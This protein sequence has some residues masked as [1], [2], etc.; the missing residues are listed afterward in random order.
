M[1]KP[2]DLVLDAVREHAAALARVGG[3][4]EHDVRRAVDGA[5]LAARVLDAMTAPQVE[6]MER[7]LPAAA[8]ATKP[9][10]RRTRAPRRK[11]SEATAQPQNAAAREPDV[12]VVRPIAQG[13]PDPQAWR[14]TA[15][16]A[17]SGRA[18]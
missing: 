9:R 11:R 15:S 3:V 16:R 5:Q 2:L 14:R 18:R 4:S 1:G 12:R 6:A 13:T 8:P 7:T 10:R 17:M